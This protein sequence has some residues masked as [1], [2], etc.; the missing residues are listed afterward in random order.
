MKGLSDA[1]QEALV[2]IAEALPED[3]YLAG[4][5]AVA[6][7]YGHR[8]SHDLDFFTV[9]SDPEKLAT[10][11][12]EDRRVVV[13][14]RA[15]DTLYLEVGGVP[16]SILRHRYPLIAPRERISAIPVLVAS[17]VDLTAMKVHAIASRG[18]ARDFW[19]L[20]VLLR[21][22]GSTLADAI[23]E[24]AHRY[25]REDSGHVLR[26]LAYFGDA[27]ASPLPRGLNGARWAEIRGDFERWV[28]DV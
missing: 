26:S 9:E 20:H 19:D 2:V 6:A 11:L 23:A 18:A 10:A 22:R 16:V 4:G 15:A 28:R 5:V 8:F 24:H 13:T 14:N 25:P 27:D 21:G 12:R 17:D 1:Q 3:A 7:R